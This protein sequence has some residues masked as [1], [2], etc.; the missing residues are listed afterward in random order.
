MGNIS[1]A[2]GIVCDLDRSG[3]APEGITVTVHKFGAVPAAVLNPV[4]TSPP[5]DEWKDVRIGVFPW[6]P[7]G[8]EGTVRGTAKA[9]LLRSCRIKLDLLLTSYLEEVAA[10]FSDIEHYS[11]R[12][13]TFE[14]LKRVEDVL[15]GSVNTKIEEILRHVEKPLDTVLHELASEAWRNFS[16]MIMSAVFGRVLALHMVN[17][18]YRCLG[19]SD[20]SERYSAQWHE[21]TIRLRNLYG[22]RDFDEL[23]APGTKTDLDLLHRTYMVF[24]GAMADGYDPLI[25]GAQSRLWLRGFVKF[26]RF[27]DLIRAE[28]RSPCVPQLFIAAQHHL[29]VVQAFVGSVDAHVRRHNEI[30]GSP[31]AEVRQLE[32]QIDAADLKRLTKARIWNSEVVLSVIPREWDTQVSGGR[33]S[34]QW[35]ASESDHGLLLRRAVQIL[36][37]IHI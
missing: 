16:L 14:R 24:S 32:Q 20:R 11:S 33:E 6:M 36:S 3:N 8:S 22:P 10:E 27:V 21:R 15:G 26:A 28:G 7:L 18:L 29:P 31:V 5:P 17:V 4:Y 23:V 37:L 34:L 1:M 13:V 12:I 9:D 30:Q 35:I 2:K 19:I 25:Q